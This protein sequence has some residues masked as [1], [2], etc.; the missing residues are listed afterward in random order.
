M[1]SQADRD[2][3]VAEI[4]PPQQRSRVTNASKLLP[5][6]DGRSTWVR[7]CRDLI[8]LHVADLGGHDAIS[9]AERS[10]VRRCA[11]LTTELEMLEQTFATNGQATDNQLDLYQRTANSLRRMLEANGLRRRARKVTGL[12]LLLGAN[13][14]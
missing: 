10:I 8:E 12:P 13:D 4:P 11:V 5:N 1:T 2:P 9:E 7:R 14:Q 6:V 3:V